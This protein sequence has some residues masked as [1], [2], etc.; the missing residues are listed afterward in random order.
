MQRLTQTPRPDWP[1]RVEEVGLT[2]HTPDGV[3]YWD[4][5]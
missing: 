4:E 5:S 1:S 2:Y 3:T